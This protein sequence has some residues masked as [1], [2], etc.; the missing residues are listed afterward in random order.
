MSRTIRGEK[1]LG[2][3]Y[4]KNRYGGYEELPGRITKKWTHRRE[5]HIEKQE[6]KKFVQKWNRDH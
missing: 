6:L 2:F 4:W 1:G 3:E 5:R